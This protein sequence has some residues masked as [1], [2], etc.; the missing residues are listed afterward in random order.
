MYIIMNVWFWVHSWLERHWE[1]SVSVFS[2]YLPFNLSLHCRLITSNW[3]LGASSSIAQ[4][5][6]F[7]NMTVPFACTLRSEKKCCWN[8]SL[9]LEEISATN[10]C[11]NGDLAS[12]FALLQHGKC[13]EHLAIT[14]GPGN[15]LCHLYK[16]IGT[17]VYISHKSTVKASLQKLSS[18]WWLR[19]VLPTI[20][21]CQQHS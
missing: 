17:T 14:C 12:C 15:V 6:G 1:N 11:G 16:F 8:C 13:L 7:W 18:V 21:R 2:W 4:L 5:N 10:L 9:S 19:A 20:K 3:R